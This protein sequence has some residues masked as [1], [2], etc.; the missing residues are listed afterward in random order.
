MSETMKEAIKREYGQR[1]ISSKPKEKNQ[2]SRREEVK[3]L[4]SDI[5]RYLAAGG[6]VEVIDGFYSN[7]DNVHHKKRY[8]SHE[9]YKPA[10]VGDGQG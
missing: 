6:S 10:G 7:W 1:T 8:N 9:M 4:E 5:E 3:R 2:A